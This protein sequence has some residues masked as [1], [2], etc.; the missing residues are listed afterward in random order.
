M[1]GMGLALCAAALPGLAEGPPAGYFVGTYEV[2]GRGPGKAAPPGQRWL[3]IRV[4]GAHLEIREDGQAIGVLEYRTPA[5]AT[6]PLRGT[7]DNRAIACLFQSDPDNYPRLTCKTE[8][9]PGTHAPGLLTFWPE[10]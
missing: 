2:I 6:A 7:L 4:G 10:P 9:D 3:E 1:M 8:P 5:E